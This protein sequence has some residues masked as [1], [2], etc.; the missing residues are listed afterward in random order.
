MV[1]TALAPRINMPHACCRI[2]ESRGVDHDSCSRRERLD[3]LVRRLLTYRRPSA[4]HSGREQ[5]SELPRAT[6]SPF[7]QCI[8]SRARRAM[9]PRR[10]EVARKQRAKLW[11]LR[12]TTSLA[13]LLRDTGRRTRRARTALPAKPNRLFAPSLDSEKRHRKLIV[14][15]PRIFLELLI[16][17]RP[18][19]RARKLASSCLISILVFRTRFG[20]TTPSISA[21]QQ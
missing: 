9:S 4:R 11:E 16:A 13:R 5:E 15:F 1:W 19:R 2:S 17:C 10:H 21:S 6:C 18:D 7:R 3:D 20:S 12:T 14:K 8:E